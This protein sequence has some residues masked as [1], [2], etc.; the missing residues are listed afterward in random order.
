[1]PGMRGPDRGRGECQ[2]RGRSRTAEWKGV[3][4]KRLEVKWTMEFQGL[5]IPSTEIWEKKSRGVRLTRTFKTPVGQRE[6]ELYF[7]R[8][9]QEKK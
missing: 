8:P 4:T 2:P 7:V 1:M 3:F 5:S 6:Q 9:G